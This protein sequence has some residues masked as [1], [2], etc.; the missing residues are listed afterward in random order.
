MLE[1]THTPL[2]AEPRRQDGAR[3]ALY[4]DYETRSPLRLKGVGAHK[5]ASDPRTETLYIG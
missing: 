5:Y 3:H 2:E 1:R 4:R